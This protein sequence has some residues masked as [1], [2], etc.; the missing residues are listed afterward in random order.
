MLAPFSGLV[1]AFFPLATR[2]VARRLDGRA[3]AAALVYR[4]EAAGSLAGGLAFTFLLAG[5]VS[6][7]AL[8]SA[9]A[10]FHL[11]AAGVVAWRGGGARGRTVSRAL[12]AACW[13]L[14]F[15]LVIVIAGGSGPIERATARRGGRIDRSYRIVAS[16]DT[17]YQ[18]LV[19]AEREGQFVLFASGGPAL[20]YEPADPGP[21]IAAHRALA[22]AGRVER[23]LIIGFDP[24]AVRAAV[25]QGARRLD[26]L[27]LDPAVFELVGPH[28]AEADRALMEDDR[29]RL[30]AVDARRFLPAADVKYDFVMLGARDPASA[31]VNRYFT[32]EFF[33]DVRASLA[34][35]GV[36]TFGATSQANWIDSDA[37]AFLAGPAGT[38]GL[39]FSDVALADEEGSVRYFASPSKIERDTGRLRARMERR[40]GALAAYFHDAN[41][42]PGRARGLEEAMR[43]RPAPEPDSDLRPRTYLRFLRLW[44]RLSGSGARG[45]LDFAGGIRLWHVIA[46]AVVMAAAGIVVARRGR[47]AA[48]PATAAAAG[49]GFGAMLLTV[50]LLLAYQSLHGTVYQAIG[51]L[52]AAFMLG[53]AAGSAAAGRLLARGPGAGRLALAADAAGV[54]VVALSLLLLA[55]GAAGAPVVGGILIALV[56]V[57]A[58]AACGL[59]LPVLAGLLARSRDDGPEALPAG[60]SPARPSAVPPACRGRDADRGTCLRAK[61]RHAAQ[62]RAAGRIDA[63]DHAGAFLG[64]LV[65]GTVLVPGLGVLGAIGA[66]LALRAGTFAILAAGLHGSGR[67]EG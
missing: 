51:A 57:L 66:L 19:L 5:T 58:G 56:L 11:A 3:G 38:L 55:S 43:S 47:S 25:E 44:D 22:R 31:L 59:E 30:H 9:L 40:F 4:A 17:P 52:S 15:G 29:V 50:T 62:A 14:A 12:G 39:V 42:A 16:R 67:A 27:E 46:A 34:D 54:G 1:G 53:F 20:T 45:W 2:A 61:H 33:E 23:C 60:D 41:L 24:A 63:A 26:V 49:G 7:T 37:E 10:A 8:V 32:R 36:L 64:A 65:A 6:H 48:M 18:N 21:R 13:A 35:G 28:L